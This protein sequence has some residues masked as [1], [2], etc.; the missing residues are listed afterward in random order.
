MTRVPLLVILAGENYRAMQRQSHELVDAARQRDLTVTF[1]TIPG[2]S[3]DAL[4]ESI[5]Q[6]DDPT[7]NLIARFIGVGSP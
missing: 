1:E 3:H 2:R 4:V 7:T 6:P 5:G